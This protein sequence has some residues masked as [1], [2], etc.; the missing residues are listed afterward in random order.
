[1]MFEVSDYINHDFWRQGAAPNAYVRRLLES[2]LGNFLPGYTGLCSI[3]QWN[4]IV[5]AASSSNVPVAAVMLDK[6]TTRLTLCVPS[7]SGTLSSSS[8]MPGS[9]QPGLSP[10]QLPTLPTAGK[11]PL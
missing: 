10:W 11:S 5:A 9:W 3:E 1:M 2:V 7:N 6:E 4:V 8:Y